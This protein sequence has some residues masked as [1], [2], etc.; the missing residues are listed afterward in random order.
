MSAKQTYWLADETGHLIAVEGAADRDARAADGWTVLDREPTGR[1]R[2][3]M[4]HPETG[5]HALFGWEAVATWQVRGWELAVPPVERT[6]LGV[7][8]DLSATPTAAPTALTIADLPA[9]E[10]SP[11]TSNEEGK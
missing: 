11:E 10:P 2:V 5:H 8:A 7:V 3:W 6:D 1:D 9:D 4:R